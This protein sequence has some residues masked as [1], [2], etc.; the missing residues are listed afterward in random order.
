MAESVFFCVGRETFR[1][2]G[3]GRGGWASRERKNS[4]RVLL[5]GGKIYHGAGRPEKQK[6]GKVCTFPPGFSVL[7][8][9]RRG[10]RTPCRER[11]PSAFQD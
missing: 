8:L 1:K 6:G 10:G 9:R 4:G 11:N 3:L 7:P 5:S 2:T